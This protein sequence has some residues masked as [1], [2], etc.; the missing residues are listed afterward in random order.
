MSFL[1]SLTCPHWDHSLT[2]TQA[3][4]GCLSHLKYESVPR[5]IGT[6]FPGGDPSI[7]LET[8]LEPREAERGSPGRIGA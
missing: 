1:S 3:A 7:S 5:V 8:L 6:L 2:Q 4:R